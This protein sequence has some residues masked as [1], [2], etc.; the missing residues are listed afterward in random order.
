MATGTRI[1]FV[2]A[3]VAGA[4]ACLPH[5]VFDRTDSGSPD[6]AAVDAT[7]DSI[8]AQPP[9]DAMP[10][11]TISDVPPSDVPTETVSEDVVPPCDD[12]GP[13]AATVRLI[14][15]LSGSVTAGPPNLQFSLSAGAD[16]AEITACPDRAMMSTSCRTFTGASNV[17]A[18][19]GAGTWFWRARALT[20]SVPGV[21][22]SATWEF[23]IPEGTTGGTGNTIA[24]VPDLNGDGLGDAVVGSGAAAA[25]H[26][27]YG[28]RSLPASP[29]TPTAYPLVNQPPM[30]SN[31]WL[32]H[33]DVNGDG[34]IDVIIGAPGANGSAGVVNVAFGS[35][36]GLAELRPIAAEPAANDRFGHSV[37][38][39]GDLDHD[40][41]GDLAIGVPGANGGDGL[42]QI[43]FG[44]LNGT[45]GLISLMPPNRTLRGGFGESIAGGGDF[46]GDGEPDLLVA[47]PEW[48]SLQGRVHVLRG[49]GG[50][51]FDPDTAPFS[52]PGSSRFTGLP[53]ALVGDVDRDGRVDYALASVRTDGG[54][55]RV[56]RSTSGPVEITGAAGFGASIAGTDANHDGYWDVI[57]GSPSENS[58]EGRFYVFVGSTLSV[59]GAGI[60]PMSSA[61]AGTALGFAGDFDGD[62]LLDILVGAAGTNSGE[63]RVVV[64][65]GGTLPSNT[66]L[67]TIAPPMG[68]RQFG[69]AVSR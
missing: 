34:F 51:A 45:R 33:C 8:D 22:P 20:G 19:L 23:V 6:R 12:G 29:I 26:V 25:I 27:V 43:A 59:L 3:L 4:H 7:A 17:L 42:V 13:C 14:A 39:A 56:V 1:A 55:V 28:T 67:A 68:T 50:A 64:F 36:D 10:E 52:F 9:I 57:V 18:M 37:A 16:S 44:P 40:G 66:S 11:T 49:R 41:Y 46:D 5:V 30:G 61:G 24:T 63:G 21:M 69:T 53:V 60:W 15:P 65:S 31:T 58:G 62:G 35:A 47:E 38:C 32:A 2:A 48:Q 54:T